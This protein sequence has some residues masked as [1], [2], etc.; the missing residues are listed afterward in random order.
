M[1]ELFA[2]MGFGDDTNIIYFFNCYIIILDWED[3]VTWVAWR[4][5]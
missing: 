4:V 3:E 5:P 1:V 2:K